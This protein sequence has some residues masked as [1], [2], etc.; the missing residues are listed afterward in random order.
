MK[1]T[2]GEEDEILETG[3]LTHRRDNG[4]AQ[5]DRGLQTQSYASSAKHN[6]SQ[7]ELVDKGIQKERKTT[8]HMNV[9]NSHDRDW[10]VY[11]GLV[12]EKH[13]KK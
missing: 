4:N 3:D 8:W 5:A 7:L 9:E 13:M 11:R 6:Q 1:W 10:K 2:K 12:K